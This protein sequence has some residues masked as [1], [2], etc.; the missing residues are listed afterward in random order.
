MTNPA[1]HI[2]IHELLPHK[3]PM[4]LLDSLHTY[5]D[6]SITVLVHHKK[7]SIFSN[8]DG[9]TPVWVGIEYMAQAISAYAGL[10]RR[11]H[12]QT[13][14][15]GLLLGTRRYKAH[16]QRFDAGQTL[17]VKAECTYHGED[18]LV[19]FH[20]E[21]RTNDGKLLADSDIKAIQPENINEI[22]DSFKN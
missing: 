6:D 13:P 10:I 2:N 4:L 14:K 19:Q 17:N 3:G 20:C 1:Q 21:I 22:L 11:Q 15:I 7:P 8:K 9:S 5:D 16:T 18:N 12:N